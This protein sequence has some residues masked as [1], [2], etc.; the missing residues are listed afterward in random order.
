MAA[1]TTTTTTWQMARSLSKQ[2]LLKLKKIIPGLIIYWVTIWMLGNWLWYYISFCKMLVT[3]L[4]TGCFSL[5]EQWQLRKIMGIWGWAA[6]AQ[7]RNLKRADNS[8]NCHLKKVWN[9]NSGLIITLQW[10]SFRRKHKCIKII[11]VFGSLQK[12]ARFRYL[13]EAL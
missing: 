8:W 1:T 10:F 7:L 11:Q 3:L 13:K 12:K 6:D 9:G 4:C 5:L 2:A